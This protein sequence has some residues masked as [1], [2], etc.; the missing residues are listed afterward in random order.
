MK[1]NPMYRKELRLS[2]RTFK[3]A[4]IV[5]LYNAFLALV[6][7]FLFW[8]FFD[9]N[10]SNIYES[11]D[12]QDVIY[13]Y[14][15]TGLIQYGLMLIIVPVSA[16][17]SIS[18]ERERQTLE[19]LLT[20][21]MKPSQIVVGK[22]ESSL[23][24]ILLLVVSS[25]PVLSIVFS[26]GGITMGQVVQLVFL[27]LVTAVYAGSVGMWA[28]SK[29][30]KTIPAVV[31]TFG[32]MFIIGIG[33]IAILWVLGTCVNA[34]YTTNYPNM[35]VPDL[36]NAGLILLIN[37]VFTAMSMFSNQV[38]LGEGMEYVLSYVFD[39]DVNSH[40]VNH[41]F[42][43]SVVVQMI[44][45]IFLLY[46]SAKSLDPLRKRRKSFKEIRAERELKKAL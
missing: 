46:R 2:T 35:A 20:T 42:V 12:Y 3:F 32:M 26:I 14:L 27:I 31:S 1:M 39:C 15:A 4:L 23:S 40:I 37:P 9:V 6:T 18:G 8:I 21:T 19:I 22:L 16:A 34:Y 33:T 28:S 29:L 7:L 36:G 13:I 43:I 11:I 10:A 24:M 30:K 38:G 25:I 17:S 45:S 44:F 41:W 5:T